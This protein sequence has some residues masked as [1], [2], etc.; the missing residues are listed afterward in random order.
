MMQGISSL[1]GAQQNPGQAAPFQ[2][3]PPQQPK[4]PQ[5]VTGQLESL[6][7]QQLLA[8]FNNPTDATPKWAVMTA[9]AKAIEQQRLM[10]AAQGQAAMQ[11]GQVQ[12]QQPPVAA[13]IMSQR[14]E[15]EPEGQTYADGGATFGYGSF[16]PVTAAEMMAADQL[17]VDRAKRAQR[18]RELEEKVPFLQQAGAPQAATLLRELEALKRTEAPAATH[19]PQSQP[20]APSAA[21]TA[22]PAAPTAPLALASRGIAT[23][24][25]R[26][27]AP[28]V[29]I[30]AVRPQDPYADIEKEGIAGIKSLTNV[31]QGQGV[32][33]PE[34]AALRKAA[35]EA[36]QGITSRRDR[37]RQ[38]AL[39][40]AQK[41]ASTPLA[42]DE[43]TLLRSAAA[44]GGAKT[45]GEGLARMAGAVGEVKGERRRALEAAQK[46]SRE[47]QNAIDQLNQAMLEKKVADRTGD[48]NRQRDAEIKVAEA[49]LR[50]TELRTGLQKLR[51]E[52]ANRAEQ[53]DIER[54]KIA[55][56]L[57]AAR[58][59]AEARHAGA[60]VTDPRKVFDTI[61][62][63]VQ[64]QYD[65]WAKSVD[66]VRATAAQKDAKRR[67]MLQE[68][69][70]IATA[71]GV[72][73]L[74]PLL[75][76]TAAPAGRV[77]EI[78]FTTIK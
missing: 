17:R 39:E 15:P 12:A 34:L 5:A 46:L 60:G 69:V 24:Q 56:T 65:M 73:G 55:A 78:D 48:V 13:Q 27:A 67:E 21:P 16:D 9:Y 68:Q 33:D 25:A 14:P 54:E 43:E 72:Q 36:T 51:G 75:A 10:Q 30:A 28:K 6:P 66:G 52:E 62:D 45:F 76:A 50:I 2:A 57:Q 38:A 3:V 77:I 19:A 18:I 44:F 23:G 35:Y 74:G 8:M 29:G 42:G 64:K 31:L 37:D 20:P 59:G 7:P 70:K 22:P 1:P 41:A 63:N 53:R 47:E 26:P 40:A 11:Q 61:V 4:T 32:V 58:I 49:Q 71:A